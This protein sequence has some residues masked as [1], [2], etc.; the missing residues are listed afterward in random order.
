MPKEKTLDPVRPNEG[1]E[2]A[3]RR[4]LEDFVSEMFASVLYWVRV[5]YKRTP[6]EMAA[7]ASPAK[8][9][10]ALIARL[11][12]RWQDKAD[13]Q[14]QAGAEWFA[15]SAQDRTDRAMLHSLRKAG[16]SVKFKMTREM[17]DVLQSTTA[18][19]VSLIKSISSQFF[20]QIEGSVMRSVAQGRDLGALTKELQQNYGVTHRRAAFIAQSQNNMATA[21]MTRVRQESLGISEARWRHSAGGRHPR[22]DHVAANGKRYKIADGMYLGGVWTW[23]GVLPRCRCVSQSII[24]EL[25]DGKD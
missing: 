16:I 5:E 14:A 8:T 9:M 17:N 20:T 19:N 18:E 4:K 11:S 21:S 22:P 2:A 24:P 7:D 1:L 12:K 3:Y 13:D 6:P 10:Q 15:K 25:D 23:P